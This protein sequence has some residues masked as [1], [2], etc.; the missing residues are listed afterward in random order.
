MKFE[1]GATICFPGRIVFLR[2]ALLF[3]SL[4][5]SILDVFFFFFFL[6]DSYNIC[7]ECRGLFPGAESC[8][9]NQLSCFQVLSVLSSM[10]FFFFFFFFLIDSDNICAVSWFVSWGRIVSLQLSCFQVLFILSSMLFFFFFFVYSHH[11]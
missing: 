3:S 8:F 10:L 5:C 9:F 7:A 2:S 11:E 1:W 6:I 4:V